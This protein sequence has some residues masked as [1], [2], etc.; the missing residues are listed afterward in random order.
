M[1]VRELITK[2]GFQV[3]DGKLK[4]AQNKIA[5]FKKAMK[6]A[7]GGAVAGLAAIGIGA[8]KAASDM[9]MLTTQF[10]VMLGSSEKAN[11]MMKELKTFA[12]TTPFAIKDLAQGT[13][14]LLSFG[15][16]QGDVINRMRMLGDAAGGNRE[17]LNGLILAYGKVQTKGKASMEEINMIAERGVPIIGTLTKQLG[18]SEQEF[19]KLVSAGKIGRAEIT[20]AFKSMT[21]EGGIFF[22]GMEKQSLTLAGLVS[23]MKDN[24]G[25]L[26]ASIGEGLLPTIKEF[27]GLVTQLA[28]GPL[29][30]LGAGLT[31]VLV[32]IFQALGPILEKVIK[33]LVPILEVVG[34]ILGMLLQGLLPVFDLLEP[35]LELLMALMPILEILVE[36]IVVLIPPL[37]FIIK[38]VIKLVTFLVKGIAL[39]VKWLRFV[40]KLTISI[41]KVILGTGSILAKVIFKP[42]QK[43]FKWLGGI[44]NMVVKALEPI[45]QP[46]KNIFDKIGAF[47]DDMWN[48]FAKSVNKAIEVF[49]KL[50][51]GEKFDIKGRLSTIDSA[52][53]LLKKETKMDQR[54]TNI[55]QD[56]R[57]DI[58]APPGAPGESGLTASGMAKVANRVFKHNLNVELQ[59]L[60]IGSTS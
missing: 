16:A 21:S 53:E 46:I 8:V 32:P 4:K 31:K 20:N 15:V 28:A 25:L 14:T 19:F 48:G 12:A 52:K 47:F 5:G 7:I 57:I 1:V 24:F 59:K 54:Q 10:E 51:P 29:K 37:V 22:K 17:K 2:I 9:E 26:L 34:R 36:L 44:K 56:N 11:E 27:V 49:N 38:I 18:V 42:I 55:K 45:L 58:T 23:T 40:V 33:F 50:T 6:F 39:I 60:I 30:E 41:W 13:Q 35:I 3:D 43:F